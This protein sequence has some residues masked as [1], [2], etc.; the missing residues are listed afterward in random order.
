MLFLYEISQIQ[1]PSQISDDNMTW[2][3]DENNIHREKACLY[4]S[5]ITSLLST[6]KHGLS[7]WFK[8]TSTNQSSLLLLHVF[9]HNFHN[10][11]TVVCEKRVSGFL[12]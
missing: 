2:T 12:T 9:S 5:L 1:N 11:I 7:G 4:K 10:L 3:H 8:A 6:L